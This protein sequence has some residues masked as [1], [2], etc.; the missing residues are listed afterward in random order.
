MTSPKATRVLNILLIAICLLSLKAFAAD[1]A[2]ACDLRFTILHTNDLHAHDEPFIERGK[3]VGGMARI[4]HLIRS[5]KAKDPNTLAI[6][7]GDIFQGTSFFKFYHGATEVEML[8]RAG[9]D[10]YTIGNHEFD[11][12]AENL[13]KQLKNA[14]FAV[15]NAN[16]DASANPALQATFQPSVVKVING[17]R[18]GFVGGIVP[19]L[20]EVSLT[21]DGVK[22]KGT[23]EKWAEPIFAEVE[24]LKKDGVDKII[25]VTH[26]GLELDREM[27]KNP[28]IDV[29]VGGHSHTRLDEAVIVPHADGSNAVV[30]QTGS[31][32]RT[33][34]KLDLAFDAQGRVDLKNTKYHLIPINE[35]TPQ[36]ADITAYLTEQAKPFAHLRNTVVGIAE[37]D[38]DN[39]FRRYP[40][41]SPLGNLVTDALYDSAK[42]KGAT[43]AFQNRGGIRGRIDGGIITQE[44]VE[45]LLPFE[46]HLVVATVSGADLLKALENSVSG[47]LGGRFLDVH[48]MKFA[49]DIQKPEGQRILYAQAEDTTGKWGRVEPDKKYRIAM[50]D[51]N[52]N[53]G[54]GYQFAS[55]TDV[56]D[57]GKRLSVFLQ[58][59]LLKTKRVKPR[60]Q[61]R[62][63]PVLQNKA[64]A[65]K[66]AAS[67]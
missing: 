20:T 8:N 9:Y 29:I 67:R 3:S 58:D 60:S 18:V 43:I 25:L 57:T 64:A 2:P 13:A 16:I 45:E 14:K 22:I 31:Y 27:A 62:I 17:Q 40:Y 35:R 32:G 39:S 36:E 1:N 30:V 11:D 4:A 5:I 41:D 23:G 48:G 7:A 55:A 54:E 53:G 34:G 6:D 28:D 61:A 56:V 12:G 46:N 49:Y 52:F 37:G 44:K 47:M 63:I 24:R 38:F 19:N 51:Y 59:Y 50:N 65:K 33:L 66:R 15:I 21:T 10:I 42:E 26:M